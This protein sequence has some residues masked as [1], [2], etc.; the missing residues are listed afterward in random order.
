MTAASIPP[1]ADTLGRLAAAGASRSA[2]EVLRTVTVAR[3]VVQDFTPLARSLGWQLSDLVWTTA[4]LAPFVENEVPFVVTSNSR[5]SEDAAG[6]L[7]AS[8]AESP[9]GGPLVVL[10]LGAGS[11]LF[12]RYLLDAFR[13]M[14][15]AAGA[16]YYDRLVYLASDRSARTVEHWAEVQLFRD[17]EQHVVAGVCDA[18]APGGFRATNGTTPPPPTPLRAVF[19]NYALDVLPASIVRRGPGGCEELAVRTSLV[20]DAGVV[21]QYTSLMPSEISALAASDDQAERAALV[22]LLSL[23][24]VET[25]FLPVDGAAPPYAEEALA[26]TPDAPR[27]VVNHGAIACISACLDLLAPGG[28]LLVSD[29]GPV[30]PDQVADSAAAQRFGRTAALGLNFAFLDHHFRSRGC[31]VLQPDGDEEWPIHA[32]LVSRRDLPRT[33]AAFR[34]RFGIDAYRAREGPVDEARAHRAAGRNDP[35]LEAY[36]VA[37]ERSPRNW[38][39]LGEV[40]EFVGLQLRDF[41]AGVE[42]ARMA[43]ALNPWYSSW[44]WNVLGDCLFCLDR[45]DAAHDAYRQAHRISPRDARTNLDLSYT[46]FQAGA[47]ADALNAVAAALAADVTGHYRETLL[48]KQQ[49]IL[50]A[51]AGRWAAE[52]ARLA[53]GVPVPA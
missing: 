51:I 45:Y 42:L 34:A 13:A 8:C 26:L 40:A 46:F 44:L 37:L 41:S 12:A 4:G 39:L 27:T 38:H 6:V 43:V 33:A 32:R 1:W 35:A 17:H 2:P 31:A 29:Y 7:F 5:L 16:D 14:C 25:A 24:Q 52:Q 21:A 9:P 49:Q 53:R 22:P 11:G 48:Q 28:F 30:R 18:L 3:H 50:G 36:R 10:E 19:C 20:D 47:Y 23:L 15:A